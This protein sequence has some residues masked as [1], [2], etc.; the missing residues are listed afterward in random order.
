[1]RHYLTTT[2]V[3]VVLI[4]CGG[5]QHQ[6]DH[7]ADEA[8]VPGLSL[9]GDQKWKMDDHTRTMFAAMS[10][11]MEQAETDP[12]AVGEALKADLD[13]LVRGCTMVG[14]SHD[15][16]HRFLIIYIPAINELSESGSSESLARVNLLLATY[17][18]YFE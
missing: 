12:K 9:N 11:R 5:D 17:P 4:S 2:I 1:M 8:H 3:I 10:E 18:K 14:K 15:E 13:K 6:H 7:H 16:L